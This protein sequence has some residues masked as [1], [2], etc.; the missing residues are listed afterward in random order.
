MGNGARSIPARISTARA[1]WYSQLRR[2]GHEEG[3][4]EPRIDRRPDT[5]RGMQQAQRGRLPQGA[6]EHAGADGDRVRV[7]EPGHEPRGPAVPGW[8]EQEGRRVRDRRE[9]AR[10]TARV[11]VHE[12]SGQEEV[13]ARWVVLLVVVLATAAHAAPARPVLVA[14]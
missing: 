2:N 13:I 3:H 14:L 4:H 6:V 9:D 11:R 12:G 5:R 1:S 7:A 8:V 10:R